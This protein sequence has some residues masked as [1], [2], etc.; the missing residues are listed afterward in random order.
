MIHP[1]VHDFSTVWTAVVNN[2]IIVEN[3][4]NPRS[5]S[6][7]DRIQWIGNIDKLYNRPCYDK[8]TEDILSLGLTRA[9]IFG[10]TGIGKSLY[11]QTVLVALAQL[12]QAE[13]RALPSIYYQQHRYE[14]V[15][16]FSFLCDGTVVNISDELC[17]PPP[18]YLLTDGVDVSHPD[19][20]ILTLVVSGTDGCNTFVKRVEEA[21]NKGGEFIMPVFAYD[22]LRNAKVNSDIDDQY[23]A[24][25]YAVFGGNARNFIAL[26]DRSHFTVL[27]EVSETLSLLFSDIKQ[28]RPEEW[29]AVARQI[30]TTLMILPNSCVSDM[31][32]HMGPGGGYKWASK[33]MEWLA[34]VIVLSPS[35]DTVEPARQL[36]RILRSNGRGFGFESI[37]HL[38]LLKRAGP[39][40][41]KPFFPPGLM[42]DT[43]PIFPK[44]YLRPTELVRVETVGD[45]ATLP[46]GVYGLPMTSPMPPYPPTSV[47]ASI[48]PSLLPAMITTTSPTTT[49]HVT[50]P[51]ASSAF[52]PLHLSLYPAFPADLIIQPDTL[53]QFV[54]HPTT[55][56]G[57]VQ[58]ITHLRTHLRAPASEHRLIFVIPL[59]NV[60]TFL[61]QEDLPDIRQYL[62]S[63][64]LQ[65]SR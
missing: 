4:S 7:P 11:L 19:G 35:I 15:E 5:W 53:V 48:P 46:D 22:E 12:G 59:A 56:K 2:Q 43:K 52:P 57:S 55:H 13:N 40:I 17:P 50:S 6:L 16:V 26:R 42:P 65:A 38:E 29:D 61:Y 45:I 25:R 28:Q 39:L 47:P 21:G 32:W 37:C 20:K 9:I 63:P 33:F 27:P 31:M 44:L 58:D 64:E 10:S 3:P 1:R 60:E 23:A 54:H 24:F 30:S 62:T 8:I 34:R 36:D 18:D 49:T 51:P 14:K 41:L